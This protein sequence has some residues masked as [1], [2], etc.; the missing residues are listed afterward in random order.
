M[1][2]I[3]TSM[4]MNIPKECVIL[5]YSGLTLESPGEGRGRNQ[6]IK[7]PHYKDGMYQMW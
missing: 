5:L 1:V 2:I 7:S 6:E 3:T 4:Y